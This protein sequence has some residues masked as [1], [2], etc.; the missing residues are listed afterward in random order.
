MFNYPKMAE[1]GASL[2]T[3]FGRTC[4]IIT[5]A[6]SAYNPDTGL[7]EPIG[8]IATIWDLGLTTWDGELTTWDGNG[9]TDITTYVKLA[10][11]DVRGIQY[12]GNTQ[13]Q[14]DDRYCLVDASIDEITV[15]MKAVIDGVTWNIIKVEKLAPNGTNVLFKVYIRK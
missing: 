6:E 12:S 3:K 10:D 4:Q 1:T 9:G 7:V 5:P 11:F 8:G 13:I 2:L 14:N 15:D